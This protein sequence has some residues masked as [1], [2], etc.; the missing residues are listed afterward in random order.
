MCHRPIYIR[1]TDVLS[2]ANLPDRVLDLSQLSGVGRLPALITA[3]TSDE[4]SF[5]GDE[6]GD[7]EQADGDEFWE[8]GE[9]VPRVFGLSFV[10]R[11][12]EVDLADEQ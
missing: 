4:L 7:G 12:G 9:W 1:T 3:G 2:A 6:V 10:D 8:G 5:V 11:H